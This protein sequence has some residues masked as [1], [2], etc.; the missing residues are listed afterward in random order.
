MH[1]ARQN[2]R[3]YHEISEMIKFFN[4]TKSGHDTLDKV[5]TFLHWWIAVLHMAY[6]VQKTVNENDEMTVSKRSWSMKWPCHWW[7]EEQKFLDYET[8]WKMAWSFLESNS[9]ATLPLSRVHLRCMSKDK[10]KKN[11]DLTHVVPK[12]FVFC[13]PA[14]HVWTLFEVIFLGISRFFIITNKIMRRVCYGGHLYNANIEITRLS[15]ESLLPFDLHPKV[16]NF[17]M[18]VKLSLLALNCA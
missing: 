14:H 8:R 9:N 7:A 1:G 15:S 5:S 12:H 16:I 6:Q 17:R 2:H 10:W 3:P 11:E 18:K 4:A 13:T